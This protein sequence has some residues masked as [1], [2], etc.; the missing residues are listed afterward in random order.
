VKGKVMFPKVE[1]HLHLE[2]AAPPTFIKGLAAE[3]R[4]DIGGIF[5]EVGAYRYTDFWAF[6]K[7]YEAAC[8]ALQ[9]PMDFYRLTLAVLEE[10]AKSGVVYTEAFLSPDFCGGRDLIAWREYLHAIE[11][12]AAKARKD[13]GVEMR[14][15]VTCIR[16]FGPDKARQTVACA[17]ETMG[18]FITGF[19]S[20]GDELIG[21]PKDFLWAFDAAR[22]AGLRL[23]A[24]AG[25]WGG[26]DS[27]R[28]ALH[29]LGVERIGHGVRAIE[30]LAL[31]DEIAEK[32]IVLEVCPGSNVALGIYPNFRAH[33]I[34]QMFDREVKVTIST[35]DPP[36][37]HTTMEREYEMLHR[38]FDWD[39]G[40]F[41][42][43]ART[44]LDAAFCDGDTKGRILK[45]LEAGYA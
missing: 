11:E 5:D 39:K 40:V 19:G 32:G 41:D 37:F 17:V 31:I 30:D 23:T 22:E 45:L 21:E 10:S 12:A 4:L 44:S 2:G 6:I 1:L 24:H 3:K 14:G 33:P 35:D 18:D 26:A 16:H 7:V 15:I 9:S 43:I 13:L 20:A 38:A 34:G 8:T 27:V 28:D 36:Y 25:E 29:D 42:K